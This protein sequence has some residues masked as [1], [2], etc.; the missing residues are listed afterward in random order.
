MPTAVVIDRAEI[1]AFCRRRP[2]RK[3]GLFGSVLPSDFRPESD[4]D[5]PVEFE[6]G[7]RSG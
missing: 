7:I 2:I 1:A 5:V 4:V 6:A 3:P